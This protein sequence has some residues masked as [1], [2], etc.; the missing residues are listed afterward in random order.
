[1]RPALSPVPEAA[2]AYFQAGGAKRKAAPVGDAIPEGGRHRTLISLAGSM[3]HRGMSGDEIA[4]GLLAV[5][6]RRCKPP[7][8]E[9]KVAELARDIAARYEPAPPDPA[10][11][12]LEEEAER[13][14]AG[15]PVTEEAAGGRGG[16]PLDWDWLAGYATRPVVFLDRPFWQADAF[17]L[18]VGRKGVGKGTMLADLAARFSRGEMGSKRHVVWI[19]SEDSIAIDVKP[20]VLAVGGDPCLIAVV[21]DWLQLPRDVDRLAAT[22]E[23]VGDV[24]LLIID[25]VSNHIARANSNDEGDVR[26]AIAHLNALADRFALVAVGVRHLTEKEAKAGLLAAILGS[27]AWVQVPRAVIALARDLKD[28]AVVHMQVVAGNRMPPGTPGR[29]FRIEAATVETDGG[30][31][32][33]SRVRWEGESGVDVE[34]LLAA[35]RT[36]S[37]SKSESA[38]DLMLATLHAAPGRRMNAEEFDVLIAGQTGVAAKTV[39]NLRSELGAKGR[40]WLKAIPVKD[41]QGEV[42]HWDVGLTDG[43]P[44]PDP[45]PSEPD[46]DF[47]TPGKSGSGLGKPKTGGFG[48]P[49]PDSWMSG[50]GS[51]SGDPESLECALHPGP[52]KVVKRAVGLVFLAC[53]C[54]LTDE[55]EETDDGT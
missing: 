17:H 36:A 49:D 21:K 35:S 32:D 39:Q 34:E 47:P 4:V 48:C 40:G 43:A 9:E 54:H 15:A 19:G 52:H 22:V 42:L 29:R 1:M 14:F 24:G 23:A 44:G 51:G 37:A 20:R 3:R 26:T 5:N 27:S 7:L 31:S 45:D 28:D 8:P 10:R 38:R 30:P 53:G 12:K 55:K 2:L 50:S 16:R 25:P 13:L 6:A 18:S 41:E 46:P 33:V 11:Q